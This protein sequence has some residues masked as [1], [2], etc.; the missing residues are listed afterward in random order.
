MEEFVYQTVQVSFRGVHPNALLNSG[1]LDS[2]T[3][4][5]KTKKKTNLDRLHFI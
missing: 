5:L 1:K 4:T 3:R 2:G